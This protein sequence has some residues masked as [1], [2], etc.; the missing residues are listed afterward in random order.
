[1]TKITFGSAAV[2]GAGCR[3]HMIWV[4][5]MSKHRGGPTVGDMSCRLHSGR[6]SEHSAGPAVGDVQ[7]FA[8]EAAFLRTLGIQL[9][10]M[11][12]VACGAALEAPWASSCWGNRLSFEFGTAS[13]HPWAVA[14][15]KC[16]V[17][18]MWGGPLGTLGSSCLGY[19]RSFP[20]G[21]APGG[22]AVWDMGCR[23]H[24]GRPSK[25]PGVQL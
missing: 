6:S 21:A 19:G 2:G 8:F 9:S 20:F 22:P 11:C 10:G 25:H 1:M 12:A 7:S 3:L 16:A 24:L 14:A 18:C 13:K 17:V 4:L 15:G 5:Y 23:L